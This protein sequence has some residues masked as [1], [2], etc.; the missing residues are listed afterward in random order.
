MNKNQVFINRI[1]LYEPEI[2]IIKGNT[3]YGASQRE[4]VRP[5]S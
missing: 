2:M 5:F 1:L 3:F 4:L